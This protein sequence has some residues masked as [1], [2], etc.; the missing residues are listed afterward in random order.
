MSQ[1]GVSATQ[2]NLGRDCLYKLKLTYVDKCKPINF[3]PDIFAVGKAY[4]DSVELYF[5]EHY[6]DVPVTNDILYYT[7]EEFKQLWRTEL[8]IDYFQKAYK[9]LQNFAKWESERAKK[10]DIPLI[11]L[12]LDEDGYF[13]YVDLFQEETGYGMDWKTSTKPSLSKGY[14]IQGIVYKSMLDSKF[15]ID[16]Q[17]FDMNFIFTDVVKTLDFS[18]KKVEPLFDEVKEIRDKIQQC[19]K[20]WT[21][22]K[23]PRTPNMCKWCK[24]RY[25]CKRL[26]L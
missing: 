22:P 10:L 21:F 9:C 24:L 8:P 1:R 6:L 14:K 4:H 13:G 5:K 15:K 19:F 7:Y 25:Y 18:D 23:N 11:E 3:N 2:I 17:T 20:K 16:M 12:K 26:K